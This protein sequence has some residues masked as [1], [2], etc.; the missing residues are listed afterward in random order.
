M[1]KEN[2]YNLD[3]NFQENSPGIPTMRTRSLC[4][5]TKCVTLSLTCIIKETNRSETV[6]VLEAFALTASSLE[7]VVPPDVEE[8]ETSFLRDREMGLSE[9]GKEFSLLPFS[10]GEEAAVDD[11]AGFFRWSRS[12]PEMNSPL[13]NTV[14]P[15][16]SRFSTISNCSIWEAFFSGDTTSNALFNHH[17]VRYTHLIYIY[18]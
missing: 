6:F 11:V 13:D 5:S 12:P 1:K 8:E 2:N 4:L 17:T 10:F 16:Q 7:R 14:V 15:A 3:K 18:I 9:R